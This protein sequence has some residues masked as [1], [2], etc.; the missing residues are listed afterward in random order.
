ML[1]KLNQRVPEPRELA[2]IL[3]DAGDGQELLKLLAI[4]Q[5]GGMRPDPIKNLV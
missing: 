3:I 4:R 2:T 5:C 1:P